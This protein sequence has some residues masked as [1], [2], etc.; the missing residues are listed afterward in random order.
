VTFATFA[1]RITVEMQPTFTPFILKVK[2]E[3]GA[4]NILPA[5]PLT[6]SGGGVTPFLLPKKKSSSASTSGAV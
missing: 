5:I 2:A 1:R 4:I 3:N 6:G